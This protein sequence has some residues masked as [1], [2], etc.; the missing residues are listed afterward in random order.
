VIKNPSIYREFQE[1]GA[2]K[3]KLYAQIMDELPSEARHP[4]FEGAVE[5]LGRLSHNHDLLDHRI[6]DTRDSFAAGKS[7]RTMAAESGLMDFYRRA[8]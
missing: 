8:Y 5:E 6:V 3:A 4:A 2:G 1:Y 7:I